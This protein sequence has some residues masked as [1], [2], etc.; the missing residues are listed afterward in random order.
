MQLVVVRL[1]RLRLLLDVVMEMKAGLGSHRRRA[2][3]RGGRGSVYQAVD[4]VH[5]CRT[6]GP[7]RTINI[8]LLAGGGARGKKKKKGAITVRRGEEKVR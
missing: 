4:G 1:L 2:L 8:P 5:G 3:G 6:G 7:A